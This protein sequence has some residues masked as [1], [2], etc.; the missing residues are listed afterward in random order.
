MKTR[1]LISI[2]EDLLKEFD[3]YCI[4]YDKSKSDVVSDFIEKL[5]Y[6]DNHSNTKNE[7]DKQ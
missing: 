5:I 1:M 3:I 2:E 7:S 6:I 4:K